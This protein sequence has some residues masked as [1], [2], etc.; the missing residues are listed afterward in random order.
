M[1]T[2]EFV[3]RPAHCRKYDYDLEALIQTAENGK[4]LPVPLKGA[5]YQHLRDA[6]RMT[7]Y[8]HR[9]ELRLRGKREG[10]TFVCWTIPR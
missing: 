9:P 2:T 7:L 10:D 6:M 3:D 4:A 1:P 5:S 8:H